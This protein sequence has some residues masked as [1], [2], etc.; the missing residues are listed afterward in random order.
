MGAYGMGRGYAGQAGYGWNNGMNNWNQGYPAMG[1]NM[2]RGMN[3][4]YVSAGGYRQQSHQQF[5]HQPFHKY[6]QHNTYRQAQAHHGMT[7]GPQGNVH[8][9]GFKP[10]DLKPADWTPQDNEANAP[11]HGVNETTTEETS[12]L[13]TG[14]ANPEVNGSDNLVTAETL[15]QP[16]ANGLQNG[17]FPS[18]IKSEMKT[19]FGPG[20][21]PQ[22]VHT[23]HSTVNIPV[24]NVNETRPP[25]L[26]AFPGRGRGGYRGRGGFQQH[27]PQF[28]TNANNI[29]VVSSS[30][31][32]EL[33]MVDAKGVEGAPKAPRAL[34]EGG[35]WNPRFGRGGGPGSY[36]RHERVN[37]N[38][39]GYVKSKVS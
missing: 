34:R 9:A 26:T 29:P 7:N 37:S 31:V 22:A 23:V 13:N 30:P 32:S 16:S 19:Q 21:A 33:P 36:S 5:P 15:A 39:S 28:I 24:Q 27:Q 10:A 6:G 2:G 14:D 25:M 17:E 35:R 8:E 11:Q 3:N 4:G 38:F 12:A 20:A 18:G 1:G